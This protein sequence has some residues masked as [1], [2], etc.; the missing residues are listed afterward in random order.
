ML[1]VVGPL[2]PVTI[3]PLLAGGVAAVGAALTVEGLRRRR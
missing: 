3:P 1:R 2:L